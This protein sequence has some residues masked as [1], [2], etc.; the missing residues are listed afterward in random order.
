MNILIDQ[1]QRIS[2]I[3]TVAAIPA[4]LMLWTLLA[5]NPKTRRQ[6]LL[7]GAFAIYIAGY[8]FLFLDR[9]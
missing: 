3:Q 5:W 1:N 7:A 6:C 9:R 8:Y 4:A 2:W